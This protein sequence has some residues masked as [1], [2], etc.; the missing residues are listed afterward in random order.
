[1]IGIRIHGLRIYERIF[2]S[3]KD[4]LCALQ[5]KQFPG[6]KLD[7]ILWTDASDYALANTL[8]QLRV[9]GDKAKY[10]LLLAFKFEDVKQKI[11]VFSGVKV[12]VVDGYKVVL[13]KDLWGSGALHAS[14]ISQQ[15]LDKHR[16]KL[17]AK[18]R[19]EETIVWLGDS[20]T[21]VNLKEKV[22]LEVEEISPISSTGRETGS[23]DFCVLSMTDMDGIIGRPDILDHFLDIF[24]IS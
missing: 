24:M 13:N 17:S 16:E 8:F 7:W 2:Q 22:I 23:I 21:K 5:A 1:L 6:Y 4:A 15:W 20:K 14:Y 12:V 10:E 11:P 19:A 18:I 3:V 9:K